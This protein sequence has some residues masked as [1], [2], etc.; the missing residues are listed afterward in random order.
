MESWP[1]GCKEPGP[2]EKWPRVKVVIQRWSRQELDQEVEAPVSSCHSLVAPCP[3]KCGAGGEGV[4]RE[5]G[6]C[7]GEYNCLGSVSLPLYPFPCLF[8]K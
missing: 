4:G 1:Q 2:R 7:R 5:K 6:G 3:S 8:L